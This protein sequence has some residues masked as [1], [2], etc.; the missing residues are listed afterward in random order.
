MYVHY[1]LNEFDY[2]NIR[3]NPQFIVYEI[4][5]PKIVL[6]GCLRLAI[7]IHQNNVILNKLDSRRDAVFR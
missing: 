2:T 1:S 3:T 4:Y 5:L 7:T 6:L